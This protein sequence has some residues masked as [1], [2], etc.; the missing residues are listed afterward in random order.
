MGPVR[1]ADVRL[2]IV[3][4]KFCDLNFDFFKILFL[5]VILSLAQAYINI[6]F[7]R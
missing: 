3:T 6:D 7:S 4:R 1:D 2:K 5:F